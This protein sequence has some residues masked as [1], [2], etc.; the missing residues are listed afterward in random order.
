MVYG[1]SG[2]INVENLNRRLIAFR[3]KL[4]ADPSLQGKGIESYEKIEVDYFI[5]YI[6]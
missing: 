5:I 4:A 2:F 1:K 6:R 3:D